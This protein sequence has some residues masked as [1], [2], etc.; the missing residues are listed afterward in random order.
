MPEW[1]PQV[2]K[3]L[4]P[5]YIILAPTNLVINGV[6]FIQFIF[7]QITFIYLEF[8]F[9]GSITFWVWSCQSE[10]ILILFPCWA[11]LFAHGDKLL[12]CVD[13]LLEKW[14]SCWWCC[15]GSSVWSLCSSWLAVLIAIATRWVLFRLF[16]TFRFALLFLCG[17]FCIRKFLSRWN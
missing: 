12:N 16:R 17:V 8:H 5:M 9:D 11:H 4:G 14:H 1:V 13:G 10:H 7:I 15:H 3:N 2:R 6:V